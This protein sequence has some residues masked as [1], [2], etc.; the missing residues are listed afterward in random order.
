M[1]QSQVAIGDT[2]IF[3]TQ[4]RWHKGTV[5]AKAAHKDL[6]RLSFSMLAYAV[7]GIVYDIEQG[8]RLTTI[9][10]P[11]K[12]LEAYDPA[13]FS[14]LLK[15]GQIKDAEE[16]RSK[17]YRP[18]S[19]SSESVTVDV[20]DSSEVENEPSSEDLAAVCSLDTSEEDDEN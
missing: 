7:D 2:V 8:Q 19:K 10:L 3:K 9:M 6:Y 16:R 11:S 17:T 13:K 15:A 20:D 4:N 18:R 5:C 1:K 14:D 12:R